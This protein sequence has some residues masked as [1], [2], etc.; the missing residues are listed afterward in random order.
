MKPGVNGMAVAGTGTR[1]RGLMS[2]A[3]GF[4]VV[5]T[6]AGGTPASARVVMGQGIAGVQL[7]M[8]TEQVARVLGAQRGQR[9]GRGCVN[10]KYPTLPL[11]GVVGFKDGQVSGMWTASPRQKTSKGIGVGSS[12]AAI[13]RA[14]PSA[15]CETGPYGPESRI[16]TV[17]GRY[18]GRR[19]LTHFPIYASASGVRE[20]G[21][22]FAGRQ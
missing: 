12:E 14:Y 3:A 22:Y 16:C 18:R 9:C 8:T 7:G 17:F 5:L 13:K 20:V 11:Y 21:V 2:L 4:M 10:W 1:R 15:R 19:V 6:L